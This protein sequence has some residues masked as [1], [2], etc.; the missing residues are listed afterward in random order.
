MICRQ[1][2]ARFGGEEALVFLVQVVTT[3]RHDRIGGAL[4][5]STSVCYLRA[6]LRSHIHSI[7]VSGFLPMTSPRRLSYAQLL[8]RSAHARR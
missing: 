6:F 2:T 3:P 7:L 4:D 8:G 5:S 1:R